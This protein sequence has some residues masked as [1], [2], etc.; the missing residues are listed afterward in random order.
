LF[1]YGC[2]LSSRGQGGGASNLLNA[3]VACKLLVEIFTKTNK[4]ARARLWL[5]AWVNKALLS[6]KKA[7]AFC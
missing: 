2:S 6:R 7:C 5:R 3:D 1:D 4:R